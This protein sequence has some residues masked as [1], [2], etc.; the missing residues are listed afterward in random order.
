MSK[1]FIP[2]QLVEVAGRL[3]RRDGN[4]LPFPTATGTAR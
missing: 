4:V 1:P 3:A 2:Q